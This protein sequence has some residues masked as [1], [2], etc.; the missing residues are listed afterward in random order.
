MTDGDNTTYS[1]FFNVLA[2]MLCTAG[3]DGR[4]KELNPAWEAT[5]GFTASEMAGMLFLDFIHPDDRDHV[6]SHQK[7]ILAGE[8]QGLIEA[9]F[10]CKSGGFK[11]L[12]L[13]CTPDREKRLIYVAASDVTPKKLTEEALRESETTLR[14]IIDLA[15]MSMAIVN[16]DGTI[17]Y[18]NKKAEQTFGYAHTDIPTMDRWWTQ[19]YPDE[20]YRK[21]VVERFMGRVHKAFLEKTEVEG[22]IYRPTCKDGSV[23]ACYIFGVIAA[24]KVFVLF[25]DI[26]ARVRAEEALRENEGNLRR[27]LEQTPVAIG[28]R[29]MEGKLELINK[30]FTLTFGYTPEDIPTFEHWTRQAFP[31]DSYRKKTLA[32]LAGLIAKALKTNGEIDGGYYDI[33]AKDG[34]VRNVYM[35]GMV[36]ADKMVVSVLDDVTSRVEAEK[37]LRASELT[38]RRILEQA[39]ISIAVYELDGKLGFMNRKFTET[40]GYRPEEI[41]TAQEWMRLAYPEA[42]YREKLNVRWT[43]LLKKAV[44]TN[45]DIEGEEYKVTAKDGSTRTVFIHGVVTAD[46]KVVCLLDDITGRVETERALRESETRYRTLVETTGTGFVVIDGVGR[47]VDANREY[48]RLS[49]HRDLKEILGR[50]VTDWTAPREKER[51]AK[52][53]RQCAADGYIRNFEIEYSD[54]SGRITPIEVNATVVKTGN[55]PQIITLCRDISER[56]RTE[57]MLRESEDKFRTLTEK[58]MAGVYLIQEGKFRYVNPAMASA[59]GYTPQELIEIKGPKDL[60]DPQDYARVAENLRRRFAQEVDTITYEFKGVRKDGSLIDVEVYGS[61]TEYSGKPAIIGTLLDITAH[62][63][64]REEI[65]ELNAGLEQRVRERTAEL[66]AANEELMGEI[67]QRRQAEKAKEKLQQELQQSQKMEAV[68][69]LAGGIAHDFN[70]ILVS[71]SGYAEFLL[72]TMPEGSPAQAD[73]SEILL[74]TE[75]GAALT[76]QLLTVSRKQAIKLEVLDLNAAAAEAENMLKR[77]IGAN[78]HLETKLAAGLDRITAD[79][80]QVSQVI[81]NLVINARDAMPDGGK[82]RIETRNEEIDRDYMKMRL[83]PKPGHYVML[84]VSDTGTGIGPEGMEHIFEPFY[85]TKEPGKGT[86]LGLSTVYGIISQARGG[87]AVESAPGKGSVFKIYFPRTLDL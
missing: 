46:K 73:L 2:T 34:S 60:T 50:P 81:M 7:K 36:T 21:E 14:R 26:T 77:L 49:G 85:T 9:R 66:T 86:G 27:I 11:W 4:L 5:L 20:K 63:L 84:S 58:S 13:R 1:R 29:S 24:G 35:S 87:I 62:R 23:K 69:R 72:K 56:K 47:V 41:P 30:K 12:Y 19:A 76:R 51:N 31:E 80:G 78:M 17:E 65:Q 8:D 71:I 61:R 37:T 45:G 6:S 48:V 53:V 75:K 39:P 40:F 16:M 3:F 70:N 52:A 64:A 28:V 68:G 10:I 18:I 15:P 79:P 83:V 25:D 42:G 33:V 67:A 57:N 43:A 44:M 74:E 82:I 55:V 54:R 22:Y 32:R 59:F 38:L